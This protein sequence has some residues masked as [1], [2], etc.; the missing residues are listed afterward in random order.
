MWSKTF[1]IDF[2]NK[3]Y[4]FQN[5]IYHTKK[6]GKKSYWTI[7][8]KTYIFGFD[9]IVFGKKMLWII[10]V[11]TIKACVAIDISKKVKWF[12]MN[13]ICNIA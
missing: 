12:I 6:K 9:E 7:T 11:I 13:V 10:I 1:V 2:N 5:I 4:N 3:F 8:C